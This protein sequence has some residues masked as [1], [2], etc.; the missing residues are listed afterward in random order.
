VVKVDVSNPT[1]IQMGRS[2]RLAVGDPVI[3][4]GSPLG[5]ASTVTSGIVSA[6]HRAVTTAG[7]NGGPPVVYDAIQTD[8]PINHG[9]SGGALVNASG[10][11]VGINSAISSSSQHG[12]SIG[13]GFAI[14]VDQARAIAQGLIRHGSVH[15][16]KLGVN[17][18]SVSANSSEGAQIVNVSKG[19]PAAKAGI[20][21]GDVVTKLGDRRITSAA[22]LRAAVLE[23]APGDSVPV[24]VVR[25]G[26]QHTLHL[27]LGSD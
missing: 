3:A 9:N 6:L 4:I 10:A 18:R 25:G 16:A 11:L 2:S 13:L 14:P 15:H 26:V 7:Q 24:T 22:E 23:H 27:V 20:T 12:G 8:A 1:V 17:V 19:S 5:L 21:E